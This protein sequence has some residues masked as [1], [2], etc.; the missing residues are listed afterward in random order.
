MTTAN[1]VFARYLVLCFLTA[2]L[3]LAF[4]ALPA[5]EPVRA[6]LD[7][8]LNLNPAA[9]FIVALFLQ[10]GVFAFAYLRVQHLIANPLVRLI[11]QVETNRLNS[12]FSPKSK[13]M[14]VDRFKY[15]L[16]NRLLVAEKME[17][18]IKELETHAA[19]L[20]RTVAQ[21]TSDRDSGR[22]DLKEKAK[23]IEE[24]RLERLELQKIRADL[25]AAV[26]EGRNAQVDIEVGKRS[27]E[28]YAQMEKAVEATSYKSIWFPQL[29][30]DLRTPA[31]IIQNTSHQ[32]S[33]NWDSSSFARL[34]SD[35]ETLREQSDF[36]IEQID[37][38]AQTESETPSTDSTERIEEGN[39]MEFRPPEA[40]HESADDPDAAT[41]NPTT[42]VQI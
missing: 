35:V 2:A 31:A 6:T 17:E 33:E 12:A 38:L 5:L 11:Q 40:A 41:S 18:Q 30:R 8:R 36:L 28:I 14:E 25:E 34:K 20:E 24:L 42:P 32:L 19:D 26:E 29:Q 22:L 3:S 23:Q 7:D 13:I 16:E 27:D 10:S 1:S 15:L 37:R 4:L 21:T 9:L 39:I